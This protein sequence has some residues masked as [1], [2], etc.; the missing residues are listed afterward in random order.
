MFGDGGSVLQIAYL[1]LSVSSECSNFIVNER[2]ISHYWFPG[3]LAWS[4]FL[5]L[6]S[7]GGKLAL[8]TALTKLVFKPN[9]LY[10]H[11]AG[12]VG[13]LNSFNRG[14]IYYFKLLDLTPLPKKSMANLLHFFFPF[15][16]NSCASGTW[17]YRWKWYGSTYKREIKSLVRL[18]F[19]SNNNNFFFLILSPSPKIIQTLLMNENDI[20]YLLQMW[21]KCILILFGTRTSMGSIW[22]WGNPS[23]KWR[24]EFLWGC[25]WKSFQHESRFG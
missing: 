25:P 17:E 7:L 4:Q 11:F 18:K 5:P 3:Y 20:D 10:T 14:C 16:W 23:L 12:G 13:I 8:S 15:L 2:V 24:I 1:S 22:F 21:H 6:T 19:G 9:P